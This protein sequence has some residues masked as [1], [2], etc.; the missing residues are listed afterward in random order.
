MSKNSFKANIRERYKGR[1]NCW[2]KVESNTESYNRII[3]KLKNVNADEYLSD[4]SDAG[5]AW[6]RFVSPSG[7]EDDPYITCEIRYRGSKEEQNDCTIDISDSIAVDMEL[8]GNTP[9]KL[10]L[11][12]K[13]IKPKKVKKIVKKYKKE[14]KEKFVNEAQKFQES[15]EEQI[16]SEIITIKESILTKPSTTDILQWRSFLKSEGLLKNGF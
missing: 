6:V 14:K 15:L 3:E 16:E 9:F 4:I 12:K 2:I 8:L 13:H 11:E 7:T 5:F 10:E 1:G